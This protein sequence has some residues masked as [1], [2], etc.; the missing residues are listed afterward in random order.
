MKRILILRCVFVLVLIGIFA[1]ALSGCSFVDDFNDWKSGLI[2]E[3]NDE[4]GIEGGE[5]TENTDPENLF[6]DPDDNGT[7]N[8]EI[9]ENSNDQDPSDT[10]SNSSVET[11]SVNLYF[12]D[13]EYLIAE[14]REIDKVEGLAR[15]TVNELLLGPSLD[16]SLLPTIAEGTK[17]LDINVKSDGTC[18]V[19]FSN[20]ILNE[21]SELMVYSIVN[22]LTQ[23][24]SINTV[25]ILVEGQDVGYTS[26]GINL[27][28]AFSENINLVK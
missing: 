4:I 18:V 19:D 3:D 2:L 20:D 7:G 22:T 1:L 24:S 25:E 17:L 13:G 27:S 10:S 28:E 26:T 15:E 14:T 6:S 21:Q 9:I 5:I 11:M 8:I 16:G 23:F 12:T